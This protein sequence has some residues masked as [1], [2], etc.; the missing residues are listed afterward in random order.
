MDKRVLDEIDNIT[1]SL[2]SLKS[3]LEQ[4]GHIPAGSSH[5]AIDFDADPRAIVSAHANQMNGQELF[6]L[7]IAIIAKGNL[8][9]PISFNQINEFWKKYLSTKLEYNGAYSNRAVEADW[10]KKSTEKKKYQLR[11]NWKNIL[12]GK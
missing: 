10:V 12:E 11:K 2:A 8:D 1:R 7:A 9:E 4:C 6:A 5:P 3:I